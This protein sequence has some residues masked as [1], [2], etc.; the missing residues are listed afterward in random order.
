[1]VA[2]HD[3]VHRVARAIEAE[4]RTLGRWSAQ[5]PPDSAFENMGPFGIHTLTAEQWLQFVLLPRIHEIVTT[6]GAL[7]DGSHVSTWATRTF[8]GDPDVDELLRL[9]RELDALVE[10]DP[11]RAANAVA[12]PPAAPAS[13][14]PPGLA[15]FLERL[16][17]HLR[18]LPAVKEAYIAQLFFPTTEQLTSPVLGLVL[19]GA[20]APDAFAPLGTEDPLV[21]MA[22]G[23]DAISRL[24]RLGPPLYVRE[25]GFYIHPDYK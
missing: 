5:R 10:G 1:M 24:V 13:R 2:I 19:D 4:L 25:P 9:L 12:E 3:E 6:G 20:L 11:P 23:E 15:R 14:V 17:V 21:V 8:D 16:I 18:Q 7:P 22:L